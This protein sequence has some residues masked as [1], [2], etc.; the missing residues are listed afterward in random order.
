[1]S[2]SNIHGRMLVEALIRANLPP[3]CVI[4][5]VGTKRSQRLESFLVNDI[6]TPPPL[7]KM[8]ARIEKVSRFDGEETLSLIRE[9]KPDYVVNGGCGIIKHELLSCTT[10]LNAHP[11]LLPQYR[12]LDPVLWSVFH[13]D[14]VGSTVHIIT[15]GIDTGEILNCKLLPWRGATSLLELRLQCMRWGAELLVEVLASPR[16]YPPQSQNENEARYFT[17]FPQ[18]NLVVAKSKLDGYGPTVQGNAYL[19]TSLA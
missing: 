4:N 8:G 10:F 13:G 2:G 14:P 17:T 16:Q 11:G 15:E 9:H 1:M 7:D 3:V 12:G 5:E 19:T 6:D 18:E